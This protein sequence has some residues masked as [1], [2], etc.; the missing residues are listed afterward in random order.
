[1]FHH[2]LKAWLEP[3]AE[4]LPLSPLCELL[5]TAALLQSGNWTAR[6]EPRWD[7]T[8]CFHVLQCF[9]NFTWAAHVLD[10]LRVLISRSCKIKY[11]ICRYIYIHVYIYMCIKLYT[12]YGY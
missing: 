4:F 8:W 12:I 9:I 6:C 11:C 2:L 3:S 10:V 7:C 5:H 1:L